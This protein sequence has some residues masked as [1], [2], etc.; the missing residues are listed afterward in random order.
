M[1]N[2]L[3]L[4]ACFFLYILPCFGRHIIGGDVIYKCVS[5][6]TIKKSTRFEVTFTMYRDSKGNGAALDDIGYFGLYKVSSFGYQYVNT[7]S[8]PISDISE[9]PFTGAC[10]IIPPNVGVQKGVYIFYVDLDWGED[11]YVISYQR[12]CRNN[13]I[14]NLINPG[15]TGAAYTVEIY[16]EAIKTCDNSPAFFNFPPIVI[17]NGFDLRFDHAAFDK[18]GDQVTYEFCTPIAAG[19]SGQGGGGGGNPFTGCF[20]PRPNPA[21]CL[22][23]FEDVNFIQPT[24]NF[25]NPIVGDPA[26]SIDPV[27]GLLT[28]TPTLNGQYVVGICAT[29]YRNG[30]VISVVRRDFQF[31]VATC[32]IEVE[33][34]IEPD[35]KVLSKGYVE[36]TKERNLFKF[37]A[38][39]AN[40]VSVINKSVDESKIS[41]YKWL[42]NLES[43]KKDSFNTK[44]LEYTFTKLGKY[45]GFMI[46]NPNSASCSD[47]AA[48]EMEILPEVRADFGF[49]YDTCI[50]G[51]VTFTDKSKSDAGPILTWKYEFEKETILKKDFL[52][53]F[54]TPGLKKIKETV[55]DINKCQSI[56]VKD[57]SYQPVPALIVVEPNQ[58]TGCVPA[59]I[60]FTNLS[61]PIDETYKINWRFGNLGTSSK[62]SP[63]FTFPKVGIFDIDLDITSPIGCT[64]SKKFN[65]WIEILA[66][67]KANFD[68]LPKKLNYFSRTA[69]FKSTSTNSINQLWNFSNLYVGLEANETFTFPDTGKYY[70]TLQAI[71]ENGCTDD[72]TAIVDVEPDVFI[73]MPNAFTPNNDGLNDHL[74]PFG[75]FASINEY[76]FSIWNRWGELIYETNEPEEGWNGEIT[77]DG[78]LAPQG[79]YTYIIESLSKRGTKNKYNGSVVL[80]R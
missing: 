39:G 18:E 79:V 49:K 2:T 40:T 13:T 64:T 53:T 6:D 11:T 51:P 45:K 4:L 22:P 68:Y 14:N 16:P 70:V 1:R 25:Q 73:K 28:G 15:N 44:D 30:K 66:S 8:V 75:Y 60:K 43:G 47:T 35:K 42:I 38:C 33:A 26:L 77:K 10:V 61:T 71:H 27:T 57:V 21:L 9:V 54:K 34:R 48:F 12:C 62:I 78:T 50:A 41:G 7:L 74:K 65:S 24:Y 46:A 52:H 58:F 80:L 17:C 37:K 31:N 55:T 76:K 19:G 67:P 36:M 63:E 56:I 72:T 3:L 32:Q 5:Q 29:A 23:P 59:T 69:D 20:G